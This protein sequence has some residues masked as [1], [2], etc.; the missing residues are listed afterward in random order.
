M[1]LELKSKNKTISIKF[2]YRLLFKANKKLGSKN[3]EGKS[4]N[5]GAGVLFAK[6]LE[7]DDDALIDIIQLADSKITEDDALT[8][9]ENYVDST[10]L[11]EEDGYDK[12]FDDLKEEML[13]SGFFVSKL[14]GYIKNLEKAQEVLTKRT[15]EESKAQAEAVKE[16][17]ETMKNELSLP[18]AQEE[19]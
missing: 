12:I 16:L 8:A 17:V 2:N 13:D 15:D 14:K 5:D 18:T 6:V 9:I 19:D 11:D 10:G 3:A 7:K 4:T 1:T